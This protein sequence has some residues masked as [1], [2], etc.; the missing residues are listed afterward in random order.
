MF[1]SLHAPAFAGSVPQAADKPNDLRGST[2]ASSQYET[3]SQRMACPEAVPNRESCRE[4]PL[5]GVR[6][7]RTLK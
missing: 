3:V 2:W 6:C 5:V 1:L 7:A 4:A